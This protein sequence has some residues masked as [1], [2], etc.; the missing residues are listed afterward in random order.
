[1]CPSVRTGTVCE[2]VGL[3]LAISAAAKS[4]AEMR[5]VEAEAGVVD[6][7]E[8][9]EGGGGGGGGGRGRGGP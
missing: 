8:C 9:G 3:V 7:A 4:N 1:M 2:C 6:S 5:G